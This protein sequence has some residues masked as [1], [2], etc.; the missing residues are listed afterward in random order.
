MKLD[1]ESIE[2][3]DYP[4]TVSDYNRHCDADG[5]VSHHNNGEYVD[6]D[7]HDASLDFLQ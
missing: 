2:V 6:S 4:T 3:R 7:N 5:D 1:F